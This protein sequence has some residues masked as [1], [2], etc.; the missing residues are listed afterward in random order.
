MGFLTAAGTVKRFHQCLWT[1][2]LSSKR[3]P[4]QRGEREKETEIKGKREDR[5]KGGRKRVETSP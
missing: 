1:L 4:V 5:T 3:L 2:Y